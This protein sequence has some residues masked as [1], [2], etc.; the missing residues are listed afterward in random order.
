MVGS[1]RSCV[2]LLSLS[3]VSP[4]PPQRIHADGAAAVL[5]P[6]PP[7]ACGSVPVSFR[8]SKQ[9]VKHEPFSETGTAAMEERIEELNDTKANRADVVL[10]VDLE[11]CVLRLVCFVFV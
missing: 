7:P 6:L 3:P 10:A 9:L 2:D 4:F 5:R 8:S 1:G 11:V